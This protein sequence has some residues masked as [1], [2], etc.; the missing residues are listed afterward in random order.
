MSTPAQLRP[1]PADRSDRADRL[2]RA[3]AAL[4]AAERSASRW[5]GR[6]DR[7]ALRE[8][9]REQTDPAGGS[10]APAG[11]GGAMPAPRRALGLVPSARPAPGAAEEADGERAS[12]TPLEAAAP[13]DAHARL[14]LPA[15]LA[16][17]VPYGSLRAGSS[18]AVHGPGATSVQLALA[19]SACGPDAWCAI[20]GMP[21]VGLRAARDAGIDFSRLALVPAVSA[22]EMPQLPQVLSALVD[23]VGVLVLGAQLDLAPALWRSLVDRARAQDTLLIAAAPPGRADL[24]LRTQSEAWTGLRSGSGRLRSR[25]L[26]VRSAGRGIAGEREALVLLPEVHGLLAAPTGITGAA[27]ASG[28]AGTA[29]AAAEPAPLHAVR[30]AG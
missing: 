14:P 24:H 30:R 28:R 22:Q 15:P 2:A 20:A 13:P 18:V 19:A 5:G 23:G 16:P 1:A 29:A 21:H 4:G 10:D 7:T 8:L 11:S 9:P 25:R 27:A 26:R 3:R 12:G 17:L 6:I